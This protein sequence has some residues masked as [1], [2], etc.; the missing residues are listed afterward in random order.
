MRAKKALISV[1]CIGLVAMTAG[2]G[3]LAYFSDVETS[4]GNTFTAGTL[5]LKTQDPFTGYW[6]DG[7]VSATWSLSN[8]V[9]DSPETFG[10]VELRKVGSIAADHLAITCSYTVNDF[11]DVESDTDKDTASHP[12]QF[13]K[14]MEITRMN[15]LDD[16]WY[17]DLLSGQ[18]YKKVNGDWETDGVPQLEWQVEDKAGV[19]E[20]GNSI[21]A[22]G[23]ITLYDFN[24]DPLDDLTPPDGSDTQFEMKLKLNSNADNDIQGDTLTA[25]IIF[26]LNQHPD[27]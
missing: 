16:T 9:P 6:V 26:T 20:D 3:T 1:M 5:D 11:P 14:Y 4:T 25:T 15:Y 17:Y 10:Q 27:Q 13:A 23:V 7:G 18:K 12:A 22:D 2:A 21:P 8:M 24:Q 19:D